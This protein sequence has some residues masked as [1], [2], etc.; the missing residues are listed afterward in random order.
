MDQDDA[1]IAEYVRKYGWAVQYIGGNTCSRPGCNCPQSD[2][3][4]FAYTVGLF[5]MAHPELLILGVDPDTAVGVLDDLGHRIRR[6]EPLLP[7]QLVTFD[8]WPHRIIPEEV[9]NPGEI[10]FMANTY[11]RRPSEYSVPALQLSYDDI[12]GRFPWEEGYAAPHLQ[13]RPG[14]FTA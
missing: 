1:R 5:G 10:L 3:P 11:Y 14:T 4:P 13:P 7:G 9:P 8:R 6:G 2:E 12:E